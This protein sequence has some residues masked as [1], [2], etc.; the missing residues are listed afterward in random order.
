M[1][2]ASGVG[3]AGADARFAIPAPGAID[4]LKYED[5]VTAFMTSKL[6]V[7]DALRP[8]QHQA[9]VILNR[10]LAKAKSLSV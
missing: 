6:N 8:N 5:V 4:M 9:Q 1:S 10:N 2:R 7:Q 3:A